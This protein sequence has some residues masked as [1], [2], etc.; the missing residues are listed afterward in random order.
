MNPFIWLILT[1]LKIYFWVILISVAMSWLVAFGIMNRQNPYVRQFDYA[2]HRLTEP[3]LGPIRRIMPNLGGLD[4][5]PIVVLIGIQFLE[6]AVYRYLVPF[7][8]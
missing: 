1:V 8:P 7:V 2:L 6:V 3:V 4:V 5:S